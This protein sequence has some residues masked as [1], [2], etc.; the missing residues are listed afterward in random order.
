MNVQ[1]IDQLWKDSPDS[2][3]V[4]SFLVFDTV[5][6]SNH[7]TILLRSHYGDDVP[8]SLLYS[9]TLTS[10]AM[11]RDRTLFNEYGVEIHQHVLLI[12][13]EINGI[14]SGFHWRQR[15]NRYAKRHGI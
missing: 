6:A 11:E 1:L 15:T 3:K 13:A 12:Q 4:V 9:F 8:L 14:C 7:D 10:S 2:E 5:C